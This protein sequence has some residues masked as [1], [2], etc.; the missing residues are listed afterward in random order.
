MGDKVRGEVCRKCMWKMGKVCGK[1]LGRCNAAI[2]GKAKMGAEIM[3]KLL[4]G[5]LARLCESFL[6]VESGCGI[7]FSGIL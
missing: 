1:M 5:H 7:I 6:K 2:V 3:Q 4:I